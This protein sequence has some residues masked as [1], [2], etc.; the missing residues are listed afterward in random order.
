MKN[1]QSESEQFHE[2]RRK[3]EEFLDKNPEEMLPENVK[4]LVEE[5]NIH[6]IELE[7]QNEELRRIQRELEAARDKYVDLYDFAPVGYT[8]VSAKG[9]ILEANLTITAMLGVERSLLIGKYFSGFVT[10]DTHDVFYFH[11]RKLFETKV[12]Q[13]Y[14]LKL[15]R[16]DGTRFD[17][18]LKSVAVEDTEGNITRARTVITDISDR[19]Q[20]EEALRE[21]T[22]E[23]E[24]S[25]RDLEQFAYV[26]SH[27]LTEPLRTVS[28]YVQLLER[29]YKGKLDAD[30]DDFIGFAVDGA[31]RMHALIRD[32]LAFSRV[33][34]RGKPF[35][36]V[37]AEHIF[38]EAMANLRVA[39]TE[40]RAVVTHD[41]LPS[42]FGDASQLTRVFQN[43]I[44]NAMKFRGEEPPRIHIT[45]E[46]KGRK[47]LFSFRDNGIGIDP[48]HSDRIFVIFRRLHTRDKY[49]GTGIG[50]AIC[51]KI[52]E[53]HGGRLWVESREGAGSVFCFTLPVQ[54]NKGVPK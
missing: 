16:K 39:V 46:R 34:T 2:L 23:L 12:R 27:D 19:K 40:S 43:L 51:K 32:I 53:R 52:V 22:E 37:E 44:S 8:T 5:L 21:R 1:H 48:E 31:T 30:A 7:I 13:N 9:M 15:V 54:E 38:T 14:E 33:G 45:A 35:E 4:N 17:A 10:E 11:H 6:Q 41:A 20:A 25:N 42:V 47:W 29:R 3:A 50:L 49:P 18:Y 26:V 36:P 24:R 28:S